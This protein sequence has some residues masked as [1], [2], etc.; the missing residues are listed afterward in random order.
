[1][2]SVINRMPSMH[3]LHATASQ[4]KQT[5]TSISRQLRGWAAALQDSDETVRV[6]AVDTLGALGPPAR[7]TYPVLLQ[8]AKTDPSERKMLLIK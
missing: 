5:V 1:M 4:L 7:V 2:L 6:T 8:L 3:G